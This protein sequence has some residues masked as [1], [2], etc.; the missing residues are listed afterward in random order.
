MPAKDSLF[1]MWHDQGVLLHYHA[2]GERDFILT[3]LTQQRGR[4]R[5]MAR[6]PHPSWIIGGHYDILWKG[7][8]EEQL[9]VMTLDG[10]QGPQVWS[11]QQHSLV[12]Q[13]ISMVCCLCH[14]LLPERTPFET[15]FAVMCHTLHTIGTSQGLQA[16]DDFEG[17]LLEE[18][19]YSATSSTPSPH[20]NQQSPGLWERLDKRQAVFVQIWPQCTRLHHT[21]Y[22]FLTKVKSW[23]HNQNHKGHHPRHPQPILKRDPLGPKSMV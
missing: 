10:P 4:V 2:M 17:I 20:T 1:M 7:R 8:L 11:A 9:G 5:A 15:L 6:A 14:Q 3:M 19:G 12:A 13:A 16:L 23:I 21:R 22:D 18:L